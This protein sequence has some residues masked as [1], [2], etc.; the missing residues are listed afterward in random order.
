M[1]LPSGLRL[2][3][4]QPL[5]AHEVAPGLYVVENAY[6]RDLGYFSES[7]LFA[8]KPEAEREQRETEPK[9]ELVLPV[10]S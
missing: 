8:R 7:P 2:S 4:G 1:S 9:G 6:E 10:G 5:P 3:A